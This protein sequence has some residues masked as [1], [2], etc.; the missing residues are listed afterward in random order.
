MGCATNCGFGTITVTCVTPSYPVQA[1]VCSGN[2]PGNL[3]GSCASFP[4]AP[5]PF[6]YGFQNNPALFNNLGLLLTIPVIGDIPI[7]YIGTQVSNAISK[8]DIRG[9]LNLS[10]NREIKYNTKTRYDDDGSL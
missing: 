4:N 10:P 6:A 9:P 3:L 7:V 2:G 8:K 5:S 1:T